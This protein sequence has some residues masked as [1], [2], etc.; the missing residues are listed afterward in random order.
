MLRTAKDFAAGGIAVKD[1]D[2]AKV[3]ISGA[4]TGADRLEDSR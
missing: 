2:M 4:A 1:V 3:V